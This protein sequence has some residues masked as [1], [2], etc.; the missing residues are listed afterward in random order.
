MN[1]ELGAL[2]LA[3]RAGKL[4][5]GT[6]AVLEQVRKK[7]VCVVITAFDAS[8][9]TKKRLTDKCA[10]YGCKLEISPYSVGA[11]GAAFGKSGVACVA[12]TDKNFYISYN[13]AKTNREVAINGDNK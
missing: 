8:N 4:S 13:K 7:N 3:M 6:E 12:V 1:K 5:V 10:F 9:P 2:G 11:L